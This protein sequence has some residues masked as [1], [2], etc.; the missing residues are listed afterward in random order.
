MQS[1]DWKVEFGPSRDATGTRTVAVFYKGARRVEVSILTSK[2]SDFGP[3]D[4]PARQEYR[5]LQTLRLMWE[6]YAAA[7]ELQQGQLTRID[8][9]DVDLVPIRRAMNRKDETGE[10]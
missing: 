4:I 10:G 8:E 7:N 2:L 6:Q 3:A 1:C 9:D 5:A